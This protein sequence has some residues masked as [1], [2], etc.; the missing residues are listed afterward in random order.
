[1]DYFTLALKA[2]LS[3]KIETI[4][5]R[6]KN[7]INLQKE[8]IDYIV[9]SELKNA[10][11]EILYNNIIVSLI[12]SLEAFIFDTIYEKICA[13]PKSIEKNQIEISKILINRNAK[14]VLSMKAKDYCQSLMFK[15]IIEIVKIMNTKHKFQIS[16]N[17]LINSINELS[18]TRNSIVHNRGLVDDDYINKTSNNARNS[19]IE[20][21][22]NNDINYILNSIKICNDFIDY[23]YSSFPQN[24]LKLTETSIFKIFWEESLLQ[25]RIKFDNAWDIFDKDAIS[26]KDELIQIL[27]SNALSHAE[28]D[29]MSFFMKIFG[30]NGFYK[31]DINLRS[32][33]Y[34]FSIDSP[35]RQIV[36]AWLTAPFFF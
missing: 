26:M 34:R 29:M 25:N 13:N 33:F 12:A 27:E 28:N 4:Y 36:E 24:E 8:I 19:N 18:A 6:S 1:M 30:E 11:K 10:Q 32:I 21:K 7:D 31:K 14:T 2:G 17:C 5:R 16:N 9:I 20:S 35:N 23:I 15:G 22:L 3:G